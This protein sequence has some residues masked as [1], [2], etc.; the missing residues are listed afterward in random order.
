MVLSVVL[1]AY[2]EQ[3]SIESVIRDH[4]RILRALSAQLEDWEIVC[5]DDASQDQTLGILNRLEIDIPKLR[6]LRHEY[7]AGIFQ[8][9]HDLFEAARGTHV[10]LTGSDGQWPA[11]NLLNLMDAVNG[12][13][14][15]VVGVRSN[16]AEVYSLSRRVVSYLFNLLPRVLF[17]V[18]T[19]DAGSVKLGLRG[20]FTLDL[21]SR[22]PFVE[23]ERIIQ[24]RRHGHR[25][26]FVPIQFLRRSGGKE[27]GASWRNIRRSIA[28]CLRCFVRYQSAP[29]RATHVEG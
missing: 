26:E 2:N 7:N 25:V 14:E 28:D 27:G 18:R 11:E 15:L 16:R 24:A 4:E 21:I 13:A 20:I 29:K 12:G 1:P 8:S 22:S 19:A 23:A 3:A 6:V 9:F 17:G 10:Y 5:L